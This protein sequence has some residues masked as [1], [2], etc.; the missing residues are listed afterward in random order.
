[1][2]L[3]MGTPMNTGEVIQLQLGSGTARSHVL[4]TIKQRFE[5]FFEKDYRA[6]K[7]EKMVALARHVAYSGNTIPPL[8]SLPR[9]DTMQKFLDADVLPSDLTVQP[10]Y[11]QTVVTLW[12]KCVNALNRV[13][14]DDQ[15]HKSWIHLFSVLFI[16]LFTSGCDIDAT[17]DNVIQRLRK[18][19][20][21][22]DA[23]GPIHK[24]E[25]SKLLVFKAVMRPDIRSLLIN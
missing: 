23:P 20:Q 21:G 25:Y 17:M 7:V 13:N 22:E 9:R 6:M 24:D 16:A 18:R 4:K 3:N 15:N 10:E 12:Q 19:K 1:M 2:M 8:T 14:I 5:K 11:E